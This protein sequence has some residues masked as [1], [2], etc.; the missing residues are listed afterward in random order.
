VD[1]TDALAVAQLKIRPLP[2]LS[3]DTPMCVCGGAVL[4]DALGMLDELG[5][6]ECVE[7][8][9]YSSWSCG[10]ASPFPVSILFPVIDFVSEP[11]LCE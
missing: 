9:S 5:T 2:R 8:S 7:S 6:L 1:P 3:A 10:I 4:C 11:E